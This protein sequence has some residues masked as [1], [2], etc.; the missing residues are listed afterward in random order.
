MVVDG[1]K[2]VKLGVLLEFRRRGVGA[3]LV[4]EALAR[5]RR[6]GHARA[7]L[8]VRPDNDNALRLYKREGFA[9]ADVIQEFYGRGQPALRLVREV[10]D[11]ADARPA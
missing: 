10:A 4:R 5:V 6:T 3:A 9:R 7:E 2:I 1:P 8:Y 11:A